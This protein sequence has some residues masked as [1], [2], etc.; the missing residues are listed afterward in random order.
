M[1]VVT[2]QSL[3]RDVGGVKMKVVARLAEGKKCPWMGGVH[4]SAGGHAKKQ[5]A[6]C[7]PPNL[8]YYRVSKPF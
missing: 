5:F 7:R 1:K 3:L 2:L 8:W 4:E 6:D